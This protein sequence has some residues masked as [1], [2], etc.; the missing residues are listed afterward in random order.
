M[1]VL[2]DHDDN[3]LPKALCRAGLD[4][5]IWLTNV[6]KTVLSAPKTHQRGR[7]IYPNLTTPTKRNLPTKFASSHTM[8]FTGRN[9]MKREALLQRNLQHLKKAVAKINSSQPNLMYFMVL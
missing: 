6:V 1:V 5:L 3:Y 9:K 8:L 2:D 4:H 7:L